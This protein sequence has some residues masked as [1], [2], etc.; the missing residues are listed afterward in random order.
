MVKRVPAARGDLA[1]MTDWARDIFMPYLGMSFGEIKDAVQHTIRDAVHITPRIMF[2]WY[3]SR[4]NSC[5]SRRAHEGTV[6]SVRGACPGIT[7]A[8]RSL[9]SKRDI[10]NFFGHGS[11]QGLSGLNASWQPPRLAAAFR[12][13]REAAGNSPVAPRLA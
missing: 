12:E 5:G 7:K 6:I 13:L 9:Y 8:Q 4:R 11:C 3:P 10:C 1:D 2:E